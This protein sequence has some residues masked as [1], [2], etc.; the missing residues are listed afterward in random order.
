MPLTN[1]ITVK[2]IVTSDQ[3]TPEELIRTIE[4]SPTTSW[5]RGDRISTKAIVVRSQNGLRVDASNAYVGQD[6]DIHLQEFLVFLS[7]Q[8]ARIRELP[9]S[10]QRKFY[11]AVYGSCRDAIL[12]MSAET[13]R[14]ISEMGAAVDIDC[15]GESELKT[16]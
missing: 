12:R 10:V 13:I 8:G 9:G 5:R 16:Q 7:S 14:M 6:L 15:F 3:L 11:C 4:I 2:L 1:S